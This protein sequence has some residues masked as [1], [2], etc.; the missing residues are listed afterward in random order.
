MVKNMS[1][2]RIKNHKMNYIFSE[3]DKIEKRIK[4]SY[5]RGR[6]ITCLVDKVKLNSMD[7]FFYDKVTGDWLIN[8]HR[9]DL[10]KK[11]S[12]LPFC[13]RRWVHEKKILRKDHKRKFEEK[14]SLIRTTF[15]K[16]S[17][18]K[19]LEKSSISIDKSK[20]S[21]SRPIESSIKEKLQHQEE[22]IQQVQESLL[23]LQDFHSK[24]NN[25]Q[26]EIDTLKNYIQ[27]LTILKDSINYFGIRFYTT[28][29]EA[30]IIQNL[31]R[32]IPSALGNL[33]TKESIQKV[34][35]ELN[36]KISSFQEEI[37]QNLVELEKTEELSKTLECL[38]EKKNTL[39][40]S[41]VEMNEEEGINFEE[42][43]FIDL[44]DNL[45]FKKFYLDLLQEE[46]KIYKIICQP[47]SR[48][49]LFALAAESFILAM[50]A[51]KGTLTQSLK[52]PH[53][54]SINTMT[55]KGKCFLKDPILSYDHFI[56]EMP[57]QME[58]EYFP[59]IHQWKLNRGPVIIFP[60]SRFLSKKINIDN[61][62]GMSAIGGKIK[63]HYKLPWLF[64]SFQTEVD[65][66]IINSKEEVLCFFKNN[67]I[68]VWDK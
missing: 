12:I 13:L 45:G 62:I 36:L 42:Q 44:L 3:P 64:S 5:L 11:S 50:R 22:K 7:K 39:K 25:T 67:K 19:Q 47:I 27:Q 9:I 46:K 16:E 56:F 58:I 1:H 17:C 18:L 20:S 52:N 38:L 21:E 32:N 51:I 26:N 10:T 33:S 29:E 8:N 61:E 49:P 14:V 41:I 15:L 28:N 59:E 31:E 40:H 57:S 4:D 65:Q 23:H 63:L 60:L 55:R 34:I 24:N 48:S 53:L 35:D 43:K 6:N 66:G 2:D 54:Y 30:L 68:V 37:A